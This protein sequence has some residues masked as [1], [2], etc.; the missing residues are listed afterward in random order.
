MLM[1][2]GEITRSDFFRIEEAYLQLLE[3]EDP[4]AG[5]QMRESITRIGNRRKF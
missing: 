3:E 2:R 5:A 4:K 1:R